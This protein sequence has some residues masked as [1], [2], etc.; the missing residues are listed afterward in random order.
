MLPAGRLPG[1]A[2][3]DFR[4]LGRGGGHSNASLLYKLGCS[5]QRALLVAA[6]GAIFYKHLTT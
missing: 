1:A 3:Q 6:Y 2:A 5:V 4:H